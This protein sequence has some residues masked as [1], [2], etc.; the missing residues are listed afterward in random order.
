MCLPFNLL[1]ANQVIDDEQCIDDCVQRTAGR[2]GADIE[3][4]CREAAML[5][6]RENIH[7]PMLSSR[8][9]R[10]ALSMLLPV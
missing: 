7:S 1:Q 4:L 2:S 9:M 5:A 10:E 3:N 8:H 6:L